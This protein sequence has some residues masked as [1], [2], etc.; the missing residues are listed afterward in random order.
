MS[1]EWTTRAKDL[2][3]AQ[4]IMDEYAQG[5]EVEALGLFELVVD[6]ND[7]SMNF[8]LASWVLALVHRFNEMYD[9][10]QADY[11]IRQVIGF[12]MKQNQVVH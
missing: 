4:K 11:V 7:K 10:N 3:V 6:R 2:Q 5:A 9:A 12:C 1:N 8:R